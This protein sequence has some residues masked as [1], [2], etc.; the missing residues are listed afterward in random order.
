MTKDYYKILGVG[1]NASK[2][3]V[4]KAYKKLAKQHHPDLNKDPGATEKFK[5]INEAASVLGDDEK[6]RQYDQ[7]GDADAYKRAGGASFSGADYGDFA[8][9][10]SHFDFDDIFD[11]FFGGGI[12]GFGGRRQRRRRG[13][14]LLYELE[15]TL[16]EAFTGVKRMLEFPKL[17][18]CGSCKGSGAKSKDDIETCPDCNGAGMQTRV[19]RTPFGM[20]Q[21]TA[22]CHRCRGRGQYIKH[23][24]DHCDGTGV[25][26]KKKKIEV[27]IPRG[28]FEGLR[29]RIPGEGEPGESGAEQGDLYVLIHIAQHDIFERRENDLYAEVPISFATA[30]LGG[31]IEVPTIEG[32]ATL[33]IPAGTQTHTVF[34][35][36]GKGMPDV[37]EHG[38]G[39]E[40]V[41]VIVKTPERITAKQRKALEEFEGEIKSKKF[42]LF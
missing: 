25:V 26:R 11:K 20:F 14:D 31:E 22:P 10:A 6:R 38:H 42:G 23:E 16:E 17:D 36:K 39:A 13:S 32:K 37:H 34:R 24:C 18:T 21:T 29:L 41:R 27:K 7:F 19:Q 1:K 5:E 9:F 30:A 33:A 12:S 4:K 2:E 35:M 15:I 28:A 40:L 8:N 3:E